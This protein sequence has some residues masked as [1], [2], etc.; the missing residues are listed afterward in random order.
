MTETKQ[1]A[2]IKPPPGQ[3]V[4]QR[5]ILFSVLGYEAAGCLLGGV[6]LIAAPDGHLMKMPVDMMHGAFTNFLIPG[7]ILFGLGILNSIAFLFVWRRRQ[8][9]WLISAFALG[10]LA[11][12]FWVEIAIL[13]ELHWLH[14]MWGLPVIAGVLAM[15]TLVPA[16]ELLRKAALCSGIIASLLYIAINFIVAAQWQAY[17]PV[18]QTVS[19]LSAVGAPTRMLWVVLSTPYTILMIAFGWGVWQ[20]AGEN[21]SLKIA[22]ALLLIYATLGIL[23]PFA[24][25]HLR[26]TL[27]A[28]GATFTDTAHLALGAVTEVI[29]LLALG[30]TAAALGKGFRIYS[31]IT[32]LLVLF[33]GILTFM[34]APA[35]G[36]NE[37]TPLIGLWER[38]NIAIFLLLVM[39]LALK[40]LRRK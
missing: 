20:S 34:D 3:N 35:V 38:I 31:V 22:G 27:A 33:V 37:P 25:M 24:P 30:I 8:G 2:N 36:R 26:E 15:L 9:A 39:V 4:M 10:G 29:Y 17:D 14:A 13:L 12:W 28:G 21:K 7:I 5:G 19:E 6:L 16:K 23:W 1:N 11:I 40:L 18:A 32:F